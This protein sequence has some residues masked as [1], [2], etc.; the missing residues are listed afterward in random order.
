MAKDSPAIGARPSNGALKWVSLVARVILGGA[1]I[2]AGLMKIGDLAQSVVAVRA[3]E[4]PLAPWMSAAI[5]YA[6]PIVEILLGLAIVAGLFTRWTALLGGLMMLV[7]IVLIASAWARGLSIDCGCFNQGGLL[8][9]GQSTKYLQDILRDIGL[10]ICA[11]WLVWLPTSPLAVDA[12]IAG[13][14]HILDDEEA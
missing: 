10:T 13:Q 7:Y 14:D 2:V 1:I 8:A 11:A 9:P 3:Y 6:M 4:L 12:W 5:G